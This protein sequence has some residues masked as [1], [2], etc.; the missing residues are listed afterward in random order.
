MHLIHWATT[1][2]E[3]CRV[4]DD[5]A[6]V[7]LH[8]NMFCVSGHKGLQVEINSAN[9]HDL[10]TLSKRHES[11]SN[12]VKFKLNVLLTLVRTS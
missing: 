2:S 3:T 5:E 1:A 10:K 7:A 4:H 11:S 12:S 9:H 6:S 8:F